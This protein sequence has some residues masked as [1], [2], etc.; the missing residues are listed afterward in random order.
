MRIVS[1]GLLTV[2]LAALVG[3][4]ASPPGGSSSGVAKKATFKLE[5]PVTH[6]TLK[7]GET[8]EVELTVDRGKD[9]HEDVELKFEAP[10]GL[11]VDPT[12]HTVK[13][14]D[15]KKVTF[16]VTATKDAPVGDHVVHVVGTPTTGNST[17][18]DVKIKVEKS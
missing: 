5:G 3:C 7:Q 4:N 11:T 14:G 12:M 15:D 13:A 1:I 18:V 6:T 10:T 16:K 17:S 9:F 2:G 8:K